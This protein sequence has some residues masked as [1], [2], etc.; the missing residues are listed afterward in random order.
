MRVVGFERADFVSKE[1]GTAV[2]G[3]QV[4][5]SRP[6]SQDRGEGEAVERIYV[7]DSRAAEFGID[8][9][10][11]VGYDVIVSY[12]KRGKVQNIQLQA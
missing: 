3:C 12:T 6:I 7:T 1:T 10:E 11:L 4:Y 5:L 9:S 8:L 2:K